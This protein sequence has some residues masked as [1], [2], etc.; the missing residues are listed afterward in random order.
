MNRILKGDVE[1]LKQLAQDASYTKKVVV[2]LDIVQPGLS[3]EKASGDILQL[4]GV[5]K[6]YA[7]GVCNASLSV[8]CSE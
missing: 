8:Y 7:F 1:A 6:N 5:V 3:K 2:N 4:L